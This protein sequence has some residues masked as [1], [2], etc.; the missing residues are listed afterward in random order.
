MVPETVSTVSNDNFTKKMFWNVL[1]LF[2]K[3]QNLNSKNDMGY[4][5]WGWSGSQSCSPFGFQQGCLSNVETHS[6]AL[7]ILVKRWIFAGNQWKY[8]IMPS[9]C[10]YIKSAGFI[11]PAHI[12]K[13]YSRSHVSWNIQST[14]LTTY[15]MLQRTSRRWNGLKPWIMNQR[16]Q[17]VYYNSL[18]D[19][20]YD[21][22]DTMIIDR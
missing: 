3:Y 20:W 12:P 2:L 21:N 17:I 19:T 8:C 4:W 7:S 10:N 5:A 11:K 15:G 1:K 14:Y 22:D 13:M 6:T 18:D 16:P 9:S